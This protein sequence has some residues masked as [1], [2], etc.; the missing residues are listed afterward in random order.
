MI[1]LKCDPKTCA[2]PVDDRVV[3]KISQ[4]YPLD[5]IYFDCL[6]KCHGGHPQIGTLQLAEGTYQVAFFLTLLDSKSD[7]PGQFRPHF[8][9]QE[10]DERIMHSVV[11]IMN[12]DSSTSRSL[13]GKLLPFASTQEGMCLDRGYVDLFC[14]DYHHG[15]SQPTVVLWDSHKAMRA[16]FEWE[17]L[18]IE[19]QFDENDDYQRV[20]W[21]TFLVP[22]ADSFAEFVKKLKP[23]L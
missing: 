17:S 6:K 8:E 11:T 1:N 2:G 9:L 21:D 22:V 10:T 14:F 16:Y 7:L 19:D 4:K 20:P 3:A 12:S 15:Q 18:P 13:F 23:N 5:P